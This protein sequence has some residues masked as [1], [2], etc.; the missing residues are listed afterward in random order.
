MMNLAIS[1]HLLD[2]ECTVKGGE[3]IHIIRAVI[4][5]ADKNAELY[6]EFLLESKASGRMSTADTTDNVLLLKETNP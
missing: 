4:G 2:R 5:T 6:I 3:S 1:N